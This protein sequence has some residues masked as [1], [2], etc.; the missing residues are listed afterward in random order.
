MREISVELIRDTVARLAVEACCRLPESTLAAM[1]Q[2]RECELSPTGR[3]VLDQLIQNAGIRRR[4][5]RPHLSGYRTRRG[6]R[7]NRS[8]RPHHRRTF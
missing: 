8:G 3:D 6:V 4:G 5:K 7:R 1:R 2:A